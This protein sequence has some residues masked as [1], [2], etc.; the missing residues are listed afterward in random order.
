[1]LIDK[2]QFPLTG[3]GQFNQ[4]HFD[5]ADIINNLHQESQSPQCSEEKISILLHKLIDH[6]LKHFQEDEYLMLIH[7]FAAHDTH[8]AEHKKF[9]DQLK[10]VAQSFKNFQNINSLKHFIE[11]TLVQWLHEHISTQDKEVAE[12]LVP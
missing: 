7:H 8:Q 12:F 3:I 5:A 4:S 10:E 1:M 6:L 2:T 9:I 11:S